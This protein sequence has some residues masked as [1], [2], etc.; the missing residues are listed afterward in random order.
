M[1]RT[2]RQTRELQGA[3]VPAQ[4]G[5]RAGREG[6]SREDYRSRAP[7]VFEQVPPHPAQ[8]SLLGIFPVIAPS[9]YRAVLEG[10][11]RAP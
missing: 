5:R 4:P 3:L 11:V 7:Q 9:L 2:R 10:L 1:V 6:V 8:G